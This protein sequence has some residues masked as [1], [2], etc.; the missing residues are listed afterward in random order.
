M[1]AFRKRYPEHCQFRANGKPIGAVPRLQL[2]L[3]LAREGGKSRPGRAGLRQDARDNS[4]VNRKV[5]DVELPA[6]HWNEQ[7][8]TIRIV[9]DSTVTCVITVLPSEFRQDMAAKKKHRELRR[10][11]DEDI[12][13]EQ[14]ESAKEK[15]ALPPPVRVRSNLGDALRNA[16]SR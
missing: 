2:A 12:V 6:D 9:T 13:T 8:S 11:V 5:F 3:Q 1:E 7:P 16:M 14:D 15:V 4:P 10:I